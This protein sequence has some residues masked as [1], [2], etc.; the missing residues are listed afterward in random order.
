MSEAIGSTPDP[1]ASAEE[2]QAAFSDP[3]LAN[4]LYHDWEAGSYD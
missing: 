2:V 3:K 1:N 4:V